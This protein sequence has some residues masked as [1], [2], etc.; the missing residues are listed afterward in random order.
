MLTDQVYEQ[1]QNIKIY[2][3]SI[4]TPKFRNVNIEVFREKYRILIGLKN[5][6]GQDSDY[7]KLV[8]AMSQIIS[9]F[10]KF[11]KLEN[12]PAGT[13]WSNLSERGM[14]KV[15]PPIIKQKDQ[16][17]PVEW[18]DKWGNCCV[19]NGYW[20]AK[21]YRVM[22]AVGYMFLLK[23]GGDCLP[24]ISN[25]IFNDLFEIIQR[26]NQ[27]NNGQS[28][29]IA[30]GNKHSVCFTDDDFR[31]ATGLQLSPSGILALL[32]ETSRVEFK[33]T[34]PVRLRST[35]NKQNIHRMNYFSRFFELA[36]EDV[37]VRSDGIVK[38]RRYRVIFNTLL[39][40]LFIN[41]LL[42][43]FNDRIDI[44][45]YLLLDSA[46]IF[47]R[48]ALLH[49]NLPRMEIHL[50]TIAEYVGLRDSNISNLSKT[51]ERNILEPLK[52]YGYIEPYEKTEGLNG[53][54][55]IITRSNTTS[56]KRTSDKQGR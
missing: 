25:P 2:Y 39:G 49:H 41:N 11:E 28:Q 45:F 9:R 48:R 42:A 50:I 38:K 20:N 23:E 22:D 52:D 4:K 54:K 27:L 12:L 46:Q 19:S 26:E 5:D 55:Y 7:I 37:D 31:K 32:L 47:Y 36:Y 24:D 21:N 44:K 29:M 34:F 35:N 30:Q 16:V 53:I 43:R 13:I 15:I 8:N 51:V 6:L 3:D 18:K 1:F 56:N 40:E 14:N 33:L 10:K 17:F